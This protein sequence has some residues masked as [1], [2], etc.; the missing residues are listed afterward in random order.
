MQDALI[1]IVRTLVDLYIITFGLRIVMQWIRA[2]YRN[3]VTQFIVRITNPLVVPL[4]R[5]I[6][7]AGS[8]DTASLT[9]VI[10]LELV[11]TIAL[12]NLTCSGQPPLLNVVAL[13]VLRTL[14]VMLRL[15]L[16][17]L[18]IYVI[19]SW[20]NQGTFNP[21]SSLLAAIAEPV[22]RPLR[23]LI[24]PIGGL[25]LSA[26]FALIGIQ[27]LTMLLPIGRVAASVGCLSY[28]QFL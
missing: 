16:F 17:V 20:V 5:F 27:A 26:L 25:D 15:Y 23:K 12:I 8:L 18:L 3:P 19:L 11:V 2:D 4:R 24:P 21:V 1:F 14:Y 7:P 9:V 6:P 13:T 22:L 10:L 28:G